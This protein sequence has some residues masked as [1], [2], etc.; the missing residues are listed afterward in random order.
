MKKELL[1]SIFIFLLSTRI[2]SAA[3]HINEIYPAPPTGE[4]EWIELYNDENNPLN[5]AGYYLND[6]DSHKIKIATDSISPLGFIIATSSSVL[7]NDGDTVLLKNNLNET[8]ESVTYD[9]TFDKNKSY[10][11]CPDGSGDWLVTNVITKNSTNNCPTPSPTPTTPI[12]TSSSTSTATPSPTS[13][14][15]PTRE[16][17]PT[18][19]DNIFISEVMVNPEKGENEWVEIYNDNE[20][21]VDLT[22]W[23]IDDAEN[24]GSSPK[25]FSL[26]I[27]SK[28]YAVYDL[29]SSMFNNTGD[30]VRLL[31]FNK[32]VKDSF[33]YSESTAGKTYGRNSYEDD[34]F[35]LQEPSKESINNPCLNPTASPSN[36]STPTK[37]PTKTPTTSINNTYM[38]SKPVTLRTGTT[39]L[40][41]QTIGNYH[42]IPT[43]TVDILGASTINPTGST[44]HNPLTK[45]L[46][47]TSFGYSLLSLISILAKIKK[48]SP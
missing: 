19:Y 40:S 30:E 6:A 41:S 43:K 7:N 20:F 13:I 42:V 16:V 26:T 21:A 24:S 1:F 37:T 12:P 25:L 31:D 14:I 4:F 5:I 33:E 44:G 47:I 46:S 34:N 45:S 29:S 10:I 23:F 35:C 28:S 11:R 38:L 8:L 36:T 39:Y 48:L 32:T 9:I 18:T 27:S 2:V 22:N 3:L 17:T 15:V